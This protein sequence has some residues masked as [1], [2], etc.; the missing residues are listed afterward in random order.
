MPRSHSALASALLNSGGQ[1]GESGPPVPPRCDSAP[2]A[3]ITPQQVQHGRHRLFA[4]LHA[5]TGSPTFTAFAPVYA[6]QRS[7]AIWTYAGITSIAK[8]GRC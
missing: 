3:R 1:S 8:H 6:S 7:I 4:A 2:F 5:G